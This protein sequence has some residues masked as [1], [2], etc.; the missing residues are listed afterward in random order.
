MGIKKKIVL[1]KSLT[2]ILDNTKYKSRRIDFL[3]IDAEGNDL[4]VLK[5]LDFERYKPRLIAVESASSTIDDVKNSDV[6][7]FLLDKGFMMIGWCGLSLIMSS[8]L[9]HY[10]R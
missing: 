4:N 5:S 10:T 2:S 9:P 8:E 7:V 3:S 6:Y 1:S